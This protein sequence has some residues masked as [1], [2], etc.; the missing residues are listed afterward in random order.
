MGTSWKNSPVSGA[1]EKLDK[2]A[3]D[4]LTGSLGV[5]FGFICR[6]LWIVVRSQCPSSVYAAIYV[7]N[8]PIR[9]V[10]SF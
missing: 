7:I 6:H 5:M 2:G 3:E 4:R 8:F 10:C 1:G 9:T